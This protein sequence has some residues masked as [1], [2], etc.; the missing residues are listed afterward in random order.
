MADFA[1][2]MNAVA[3]V[4]LAAQEWRRLYESETA[5]TRT[6]EDRLR[7]TLHRLD[8]IDGARGVSVFRNSEQPSDSAGHVEALAD[9]MGSDHD[10]AM[11]TDSCRRLAELWEPEQR[12]MIRNLCDNI[13]RLR[14]GTD[15]KYLA[16]NLAEAVVGGFK[17][18]I[19]EFVQ[20]VEVALADE[21]APGP[22]ADEEVERSGRPE[23]DEKP[24]AD[25]AGSDLAAPDAGTDT[26]VVPPTGPNRA[27]AP[28][29]RSAP[30]VGDGSEL[31][32]TVSLVADAFRERG[33]DYASSYAALAVDVLLKAGKLAAPSAVDERTDALRWMLSLEQRVVLRQT[34]EHALSTKY[35][36]EP[37]GRFVGI[38]MNPR[39][40]ADVV[41]EALG[42]APSQGKGKDG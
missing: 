31:A 36:P 10:W 25:T 26:G 28:V 3:K 6:A 40:A 41:M 42:S 22:G 24:V 23:P 5:V 13:D 38:W 29:V 8:E 30:D 1:D 16:R 39:E 37:T 32:A 34:I 2:A 4:V 11:N 9:A 27:P 7:Y 21:S 20:A 12:A 18:R 35:G 19:A 17:P 15:W 14:S 33:W